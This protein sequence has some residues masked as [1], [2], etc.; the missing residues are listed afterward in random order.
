MALKY[1]VMAPLQ[2]LN[3]LFPFHRIIMARFLV[4]TPAS[5]GDGLEEMEQA[6]PSGASTRQV[7][8]FFVTGA[9]AE[10][11]SRSGS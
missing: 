7:T 8:I 11:G 6:D 2:Q 1:L 4:I 10:G 9:G 5:G 3:T